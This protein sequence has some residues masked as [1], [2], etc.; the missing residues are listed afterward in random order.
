MGKRTNF[1]DGVKGEIK[2]INKEKLFVCPNDNGQSNKF[3]KAGESSR[4][5]LLQTENSKIQRPVVV[6]SVTTT[7]DAVLV[8]FDGLKSATKKTLAKL[9]RFMDYEAP[10]PV[11]KE[12]TKGDSSNE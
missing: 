10:K 1:L 11:R 12:E 3:D 4:V 5:V 7:S 8:K 9:T 6:T 2:S